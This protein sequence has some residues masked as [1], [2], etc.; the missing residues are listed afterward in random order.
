MNQQDAAPAVEVN[1]S[2][3]GW[4]AE[5]LILGGHPEQLAGIMVASGIAEASARAEVDAALRSPY[6]SG[7]SRLHNR[8][9]KRDWVLGIQSRLNRLAQAEVPRRARLS[10]DAFLHDYYRRNQPVIITGMLEDCQASNKWSFDYL[11][12]ALGGREVEVQFGRDADADYELNSVAHRRRLPFADYVELVRNAGVT[13]D[14]YMTANNDGH[15]QDALRQLM[16]DLPPLSEYLSE[17]GGFFWF[18]PAGTITPFHHDLTNNFM[19]QVAGRK[20]VRL[21]APCD[22]PNIYNQRHCFSQVD[23]RAI[24]LQRFP[25]MANVTVIDCVLAPGEILFLPVGWWHFVEALD[26]SITVSTTRFRWDN[27]FYS[28]Y[29]SNQ[30]Y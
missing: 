24:D 30:D 19:I 27:D 29:P 22:T 16:A 7:V 5:N 11:S 28:H 3:R 9:A 4:I 20:R 21:I 2:W 8:L 25:L 10:G 13:N 12:T 6:L 23:G 18:G 15:N 14:F 1:D 17:A 26:V